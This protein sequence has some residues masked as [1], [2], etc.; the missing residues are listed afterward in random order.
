MDNIHLNEFHATNEPLHRIQHTKLF[1]FRFYRIDIDF[2]ELLFL[3]LMNS[4]SDEFPFK[5]N[6]PEEREENRQ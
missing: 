1:F 3:I 5:I 2:I 4:W 6:P